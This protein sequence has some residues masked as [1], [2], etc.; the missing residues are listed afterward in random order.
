MIDY[1]FLK[2]SD[3]EECMKIVDEVRRKN[4]Y[5]HIAQMCTDEC[6]WVIYVGYVYNYYRYSASDAYR[7]WSAM[8]NRQDLGRLM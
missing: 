7:M 3:Q 4:L 6:N 2:D 1:R 8:G 5:P